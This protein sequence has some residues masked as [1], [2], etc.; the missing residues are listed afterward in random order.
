M[1]YGAMTSEYDYIE[2]SIMSWRRAVASSARPFIEQD[3]RYFR[4]ILNDWCE[5]AYVLVSAEDPEKIEEQ[6]YKDCFH[7]NYEEAKKSIN[8]WFDPVLSGS[9]GMRM[10]RLTKAEGERLR[11][12]FEN[13]EAK[14][15]IQPR[16]LNEGT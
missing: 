3:S 2:E 13:G 5:R 1:N 14:L 16:R 8:E 7:T 12:I 4:S 9:P 10:I 11:E 6:D 15:K